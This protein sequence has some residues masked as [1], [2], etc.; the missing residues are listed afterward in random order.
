ML[1]RVA[2]GLIENSQFEIH[3]VEPGVESGGPLE[4][5]EGQIALATIDAFVR[6]IRR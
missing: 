3:T 1:Y 2:F 4:Q 5:L 6:E